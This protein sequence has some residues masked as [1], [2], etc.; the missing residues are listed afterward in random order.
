MDQVCG[1]SFGFDFEY[2]KR[3]R[4][5][6]KSQVVHDV[7]CRTSLERRVRLG[8][9]DGLIEMVLGGGESLQKEGVGQGWD[10]VIEKDLLEDEAEKRRKR[11]KKIVE[12]GLLRLWKSEEE[13][14]R[15]VL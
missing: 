3:K 6:M 15:W 4:R 13:V 2:V 11:M 5:K 12:K 8:D 14:V 1:S 9:Q 7:V 10:R